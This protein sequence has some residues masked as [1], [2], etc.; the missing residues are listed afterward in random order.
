MTGE[1]PYD[2]HVTVRA[3]SRQQAHNRLAERLYG[4]DSPTSAVRNV[5][6]FTF[7][8]HTAALVAAIEERGELEALRHF[9]ATIGAELDASRGDPDADPWA[10]LV[11]VHGE[12]RDRINELADA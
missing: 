8:G 9:A 12:M 3:P 11:G 6:R 1:H 7:G 4:P 10:I 5:D 2:F